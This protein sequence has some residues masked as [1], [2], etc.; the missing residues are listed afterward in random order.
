MNIAG[1]VLRISAT[2]WVDHVFDVAIYYSSLRRK[3][4][5]KQVMLFVHKTSMGDAIVGYGVVESACEKQELPEH[6]RQEC[7][8]HGWNKALLFE[9]VMRFRKPLLI[10]ETF[11]REPQ[12][13]GRYCHGL[14]LS[15]KEITSILKQAER[16][17]E[18]NQKP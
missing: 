4:K 3:W 15:D 14:Q 7:E 6:E 2:E 9:Y 8:R 16:L 11:L 13:R 10:K 12:F 17:Q 18:E 1:Y 5:P